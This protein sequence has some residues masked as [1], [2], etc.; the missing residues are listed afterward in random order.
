MDDV[1][2]SVAGPVPTTPRAEKDRV[3]QVPSLLTPEPD[4]LPEGE[5][6]RR[7]RPPA[8]RAISGPDEAALSWYFGQGLSIYEKS[9]FGTIV[10]KIAMDGY[11][12]TTCGKCD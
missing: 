12:S 1:P 9:T 6:P 8:P 11:A 10:Q 5:T 7:R 3:S 4:P 2:T